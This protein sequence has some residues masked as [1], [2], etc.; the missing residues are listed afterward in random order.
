MEAIIMGAHIG[1]DPMAFDQTRT[2]GCSVYITLSY[3]HYPNG[4]QGRRFEK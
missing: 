3:D 2:V 4:V 1:A